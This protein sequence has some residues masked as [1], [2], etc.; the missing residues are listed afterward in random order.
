MHTQSQEQP[1]N[2]IAE[3][4]A[5]LA[6]VNQKIAEAEREEKINGRALFVEN[7]MKD[8]GLLEEGM[9]L[10]ETFLD[11]VF[12]MQKNVEKY[13]KS[14]DEEVVLSLACVSVALDEISEKGVFSHMI[15]ELVGDELVFILVESHLIAKD[16]KFPSTVRALIKMKKEE[17]PNM[18]FI[19][20][21]FASIEERKQKYLDTLYTKGE[22]MYFDQ[23]SGFVGLQDFKREGEKEDEETIH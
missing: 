8:I 19:D 22:K 17:K 3:L 12:V 14:G 23:E 16:S 21:L 6:V 20:M 1:K 5:Q 4:E 10:D 15:D 18:L 7:K 9:H 13:I 11:K 2:N